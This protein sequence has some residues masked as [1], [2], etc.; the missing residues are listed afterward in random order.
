[1]AFPLRL[2]G[3]GEQGGHLLVVVLRTRARTN[4]VD[5]AEE[6]QGSRLEYWNDGMV[7]KIYNLQSKIK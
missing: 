7:G 4:P 3:Y 5:G 6:N 1:L 2:S